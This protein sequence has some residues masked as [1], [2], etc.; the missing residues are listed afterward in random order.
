M[1]LNV[2]LWLGSNWWL[3]SLWRR[4]ARRVPIVPFIVKKMILYDLLVFIM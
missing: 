1:F 2:Y 4:R 3:R